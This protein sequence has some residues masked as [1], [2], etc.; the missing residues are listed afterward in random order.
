MNRSVR[1]FAKPEY[2]LRPSQ[3]WR[4]LQWHFAPANE[5][6]ISVRLPWGAQIR[7]RPT[8]VIGSAIAKLGLFDLLVSESLF[9]LCDVGEL[10]LDIGANIGQMTSLMAVKVGP[11]GTVLAFEPH[12][13]IFSELAFNVN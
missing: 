13:E 12:F 2:L 3:L 7:V 5:T 10:A 8:D 1:S 11:S 6:Y 4:R 9:R